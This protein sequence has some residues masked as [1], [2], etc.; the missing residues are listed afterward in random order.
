MLFGKMTQDQSPLSKSLNKLRSSGRISPIYEIR[1]FTRN[2]KY[3]ME[4]SN[5]RNVIFN[6]W[7]KFKLKN[8]WIKGS[9]TL[10]GGEKE[11]QIVTP[12]PLECGSYMSF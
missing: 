1:Y 2:P 7:P 10:G 11:I 3:K 9:K 6:K 8:S 5:L 12:L 4:K